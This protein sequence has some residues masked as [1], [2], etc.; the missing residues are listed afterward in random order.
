MTSIVRAAK[1]INTPLISWVNGPCMITSR[2]AYE[3]PQGFGLVNG[4]N[5]GPPVNFLFQNLIPFTYANNVLDIDIDMIVPC[6]PFGG[7]SF[8]DTM[9][10]TIPDESVPHFPTYFNFPLSSQVRM[11]GGT[12]LV[13][14]IGANFRE[15]IVTLYES[16]YEDTV[17]SI[18]VYSNG[19]AT[20]VQ[21]LDVTTLGSWLSIINPTVGGTYLSGDSTEP[22]VGEYI[23]PFAGNN[24]G[25]TYVFTHPLTIA[26]T[27]VSNGVHYFTL[28]SQISTG[29]M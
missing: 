14:D 2:N 18:K 28:K 27:M 1:S 9:M 19:I 6:Y 11:M 12:N 15:Y 22:P 3:P 10:T 29:K 23:S 8:R 13:S 24:Y 17:T 16:R 4:E 21:V 20:K 25:V 7:C 26:V 5:N